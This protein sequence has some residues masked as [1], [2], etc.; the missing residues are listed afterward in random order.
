M[1]YR[2]PAAIWPAEPLPALAGPMWLTGE[3]LGIRSCA[4]VANEPFGPA[5][6]IN[7]FWGGPL[8]IWALSVGLSVSIPNYCPQLTPSHLHLPVRGRVPRRR[9]AGIDR[10]SIPCTPSGFPAPTLNCPLELRHRSETTRI[11][12]RG[13]DVCPCHDCLAVAAVSKDPSNGCEHDVRYVP[14]GLYN[15][16]LQGRLG[17]RPDWTCFRLGASCNDQCWRTRSPRS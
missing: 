10:Q 17:L 7:Q 6:G 8:P 1:G 14:D 15:G 12:N 13:R 9:G 2:P 4:G 3:T 11:G 16:G 5:S